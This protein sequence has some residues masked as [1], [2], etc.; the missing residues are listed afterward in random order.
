MQLSSGEKGNQTPPQPDGHREGHTGERQEATG[1]EGALLAG[2]AD[3]HQNKEG[4]GR[5]LR[6]RGQRRARDPIQ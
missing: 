5:Q 4:R 3:C 1:G 2:A 6:G